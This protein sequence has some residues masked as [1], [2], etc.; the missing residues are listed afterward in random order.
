[1]TDWARGEMRVIG[2]SFSGEYG[3]CPIVFDKDQQPAHELLYRRFSM[4]VP[5]IDRPLTG[6]HKAVFHD[7]RPVSAERM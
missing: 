4:C 7:I 6:D 1:M 5:T 3:C 2:R